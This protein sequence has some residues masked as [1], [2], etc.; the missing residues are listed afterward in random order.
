MP[1]VD[2]LRVKSLLGSLV[3]AGHHSL[4]IGAVGVG[5][6]MSITSTLETLPSGRSHCVINFSAQT[7]S[8]S[9]QAGSCLLLLAD[10]YHAGLT[11]RVVP[12]TCASIRTFMLALFHRSLTGSNVLYSTTQFTGCHR[13]Q[14]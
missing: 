2:T 13:S 4:L 8:N 12:C 3:A 11:G 6:T 5:K 1:T 9:L 14:A 7:T 10:L